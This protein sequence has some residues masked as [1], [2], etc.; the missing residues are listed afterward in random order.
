MQRFINLGKKIY[1]MDN[2]REVHRMIVFVVRACLH[3]GTMQELFAYFS[4]NELLHNIA[5]QYPYVYEQPT[6]AFFYKDSTFAERAKLVEEHMDFLT[7]HLREDVVKDLYRVKS[8]ALWQDSYEDKLLELVL[9]F[10]PGQR[11]EGLLSVML[12]LG[13]QSLYQIVFWISKDKTDEWAMWIG[14]M[15]GP[16]MDNAKEIVKKI[17]KKCFAY[18]TKNLI[19][20]AAQA[21]A[22]ELD[23]AGIYAVTNEGYYA[24]NHVRMDRKLK[25]SFSDFWQEAGGEPCG[26]K[27]FFKLPRREHRK[28]IEEVPTRK[29]AVYR[30]RFALLDE[31]DA[32]IKSHIEKLL[33]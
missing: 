32:S 17:T 19:L 33:K 21:I 23:L 28:T 26:D 1:N 6:R 25:T 16:N 24:N 9:Q 12:K 22:R 20:Y 15:Q 7:E 2:P 29:R 8:I 13:D 5:E 27:R 30:K 11:K 31:I 3:R 4:K 18:R 14:A 10:E